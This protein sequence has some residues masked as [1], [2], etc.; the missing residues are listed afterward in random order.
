[1]CKEY[2]Q[3]ITAR[4]NTWTNNFDTK[5][6]GAQPLQA[7]VFEES[8]THHSWQVIDRLSKPDSEL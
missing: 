5:F 1:M 4:Q 6:P 7:I 3:D 8:L 2:T